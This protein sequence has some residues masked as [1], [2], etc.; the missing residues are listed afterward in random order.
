MT[1]RLLVTL[2]LIPLFALAS[3]AVPSPPPTPSPEATVGVTTADPTPVDT[4]QD[5]EQ[6]TLSLDGIGPIRLAETV[7]VDLQ[8]MFTDG[9]ECFGPLLHHPDHG[10]I[11]IWTDEGT[12]DATVTAIVLSDDSTAT[13]EGIRVGMALAEG[14]GAY[15]ELTRSAE[16]DQSDTF[17]IYTVD[18]GP[19]SLYFEVVNGVVA[20][21]SLQPSAAFWPASDRSCGGP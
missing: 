2:A 19:I 20:A 18:G 14:E 10:D 16:A 12:S 13:S 8:A 4:A 15:P 21:I 9:W 3:C 7:P 1:P 11:E 5:P 17:R 6:W